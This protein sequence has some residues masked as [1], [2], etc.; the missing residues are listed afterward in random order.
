[1]RIYVMTDLEGVAGVR[2]FQEWTSPDKRYYDLARELLTE[3]LNAAIDGFLAGGATSI[4]VADGHGPSAIDIVRLDPRVELLRGW[5]RGWPLGLEEGGFDAIAWVGQHAKSRTEFSNMA[6]TQGCRYLELSVNGTAIG[7]FGQMAMCASELG[8]RAIFA[9]GELAFTAEAQTLVPGIETVA[10][11]RGTRPGRG[12]ECTE[13]QYRLRNKG[14]IHQHPLRVREMIR[15]GAERAVRRAREEDFGLVPMQSPFRRTLVY[16]ATADQP[17]MVTVDEHPDS[18][19]ALMNK[20]TD[21]KPL[22]SDEKLR[23]Y[24]VD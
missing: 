23:E 22:E 12:D 9:A 6:H 21:M 18:F 8:V 2:D 5:G 7:E 14:A 3:E 13:E 4:L 24:L 1:M 10:G 15:K 16:R 20:P 11:K 17:R 19:A